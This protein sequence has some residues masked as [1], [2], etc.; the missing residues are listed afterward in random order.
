MSEYE[1][2]KDELDRSESDSEMNKDEPS[3]TK[4]ESAKRALKSAEQILR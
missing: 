1:T 4:S 3:E 2:D